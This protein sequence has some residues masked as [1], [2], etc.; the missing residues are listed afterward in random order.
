MNQP[1]RIMYALI[2]VLAVILVVSI[3][4]HYL[5]TGT[6]A[7]TTNDAG[8]LIT[9]TEP[10]AKPHK[11]S[12]GHGSVRL[13]PGKYVV[14]VT[15]GDKA[16]TAIAQV[17]RGKKT[18]ISIA[19]VSP[20][21]VD[22]KGDF[23]AKS[24]VPDAAGVTF[25]NSPFK[26]LFHYDGATAVTFWPDIY[27]VAAIYW[28]S[29]HTAYI[30]NPDGN[31]QYVVDGHATGPTAGQDTTIS[32]PP[33]SFA[34][35]SRGELAYVTN[36]SVEVVDQPGAAPHVV[37]SLPSSSWGIALSERGDILLH[38]TS[39][40]VE[41]AVKHNKS[42]YLPVDGSP[43]ELPDA[44]S[45]ITSASISPDGTHLIYTSDGSTGSYDLKAN[46][47]GVSIAL[48]PTHPGSATWVGNTKVIYAQGTSIWLFDFASSTSA[49]IS[50]ING[51][52]TVDR[53]FTV[54]PD[55]QVYF[56]TDPS[57][58]GSGGQ[59]YHFKL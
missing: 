13:A 57:A 46:A 43:R 22:T 25:L 55:G 11:L 34:I 33:Q 54:T 47:P 53:P 7:V 4:Y 42:R 45:F 52:L 20:A 2:A 18:A 31:L 38:D 40:G 3:S 37:A 6:I 15:S 56:G 48:Q 51:S 16:S 59:I 10:G 9:V 44:L 29:P 30:L 36:K 32:L 28:L 39:E 41:K 5:S 50:A 49:K 14:D 12:H 21:V 23:T 58:D 8:S 24:I 35:N 19:L 26:Q 27:P 17:A 1:R